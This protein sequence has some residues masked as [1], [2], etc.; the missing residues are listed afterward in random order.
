MQ[1][2]LLMVLWLVLVLRM[3]VLPAPRNTPTT[4]AIASNSA[5]PMHRRP[6]IGRR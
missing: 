1:S 4:P 3:L 5:L 2:P 6:E